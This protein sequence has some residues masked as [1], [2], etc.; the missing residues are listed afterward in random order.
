MKDLR[1]GIV[2][3]VQLQVPTVPADTASL[4]IEL[5]RLAVKVRP[6]NSTPLESREPELVIRGK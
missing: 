1:T 5:E 4:V 6:V 2:E 3:P